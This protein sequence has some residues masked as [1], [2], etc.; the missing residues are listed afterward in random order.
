MPSPEVTR[1]YQGT[2]GAFARRS[3]RRTEVGAAASFAAFRED[4]DWIAARKASEAR[5]GGSLTADGGVKSLFLRP[6][7]YSATR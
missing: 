2:G 3:D 4:P 6:T 7:D 1:W 5:A